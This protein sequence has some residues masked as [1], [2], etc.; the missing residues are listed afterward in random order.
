MLKLKRG[1]GIYKKLAQVFTEIE[2]RMIRMEN[3]VRNMNKDKGNSGRRLDDLDPVQGLL[4]LLKKV[5]ASEAVEFA[6]D[7]IADQSGL[8][9]LN[10]RLHHSDELGD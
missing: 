4:E 7:L 8:N 10:D 9:A 5:L 3:S 1:E 2:I 6:T